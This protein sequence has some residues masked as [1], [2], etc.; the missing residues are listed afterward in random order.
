[1]KKHCKIINETGLNTV[2]KTVNRQL[3][4][5]KVYRKVLII[6]HNNVQD[7]VWKNVQDNVSNNVQDNVW[8]NVKLFKYN[9]F[10]QYRDN[11]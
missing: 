3:L 6:V 5:Y 2:Y 11:L 9:S 8:K 10:K 1:M 7:N 4:K